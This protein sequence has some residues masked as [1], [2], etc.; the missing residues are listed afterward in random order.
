[1]EGG[2]IV[3]QPTANINQKCC[4]RSGK[5]KTLF[6][7]EEIELFFATLETSEGHE[8]IESFLLLGN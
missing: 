5:F 6:R 8:S 2:D 7:G 1:M 3:A 4:T